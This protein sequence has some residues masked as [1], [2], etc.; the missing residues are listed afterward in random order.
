[1]GKLLLE[2]AEMAHRLVL[3]EHER[4]GLFG[5]VARINDD[6][7]AY[8]F[9]YWLTPQ[10]W[11]ILLEVADRS[12]PG[13]AQWV[14]RETCRTAMAQGAVS[15]N[16]MDD[17]GLPGLRAAKLAYRPSTILNIWT[18]TRMTA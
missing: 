18:I 12:I 5:T 7:A 1:M 15:L 13:L 8:T 2:D 4:I 10:T 14:F 11:C 17:A 3:Q 6:I 16:A 9:G